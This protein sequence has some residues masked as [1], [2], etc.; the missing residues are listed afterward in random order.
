MSLD[1][2]AAWGPPPAQATIR[3]QP[4][5]FQV[6]EL[7]GFEPCGEGEHAYLLLEKR[8]LNT[9][10]VVERIADLSGVRVRDIGYC[11][12]KDRNACAR[13]WFSIGLAGRPQPDWAALQTQGGIRVLRQCHHRRKLRRDS[14]RGNRFCLRLRNLRCDRA[15]LERRLEQVRDV[16]VPNY[17]GE[18]RFGRGGSTL[19]GA[20]RWVE[21][22]RRP[23]AAR[24]GLYLSALRA[25][26]FNQLLAQ[27]VQRDS[28]NRLSPGEPCM[29]AGSRSFFVCTQEDADLSR[30]LAAGDIH[31]GLPLWGRAAP[32]A[33]AMLSGYRRILTQWGD[34][35]AFLEE[36]GVDVG[37][38]SA[39]L[40]PDDFCWQFCE[41][42]A[43]QL[44]FA[45]GA[46]SYATALLREFVCYSD[47]SGMGGSGSEQG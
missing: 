2:P 28:W 13:Q 37:W 44:D 36:A 45:L 30:R 31:P 18:Q 33:A 12:L 23:S 5:D 20:R 25:Y 4:E 47:G 9:R 19:S 27:R 46:G 16:G 15:L 42:G 7:L 29:L 43:L 41:D 39:R 22:G 10:D 35:C 40:L 14:H 21:G 24:R 17:F 38:R 26:L 11:G 1:W 3:A 8:N 32:G 34:I 6:T